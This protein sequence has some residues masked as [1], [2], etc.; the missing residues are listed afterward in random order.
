MSPVTLYNMYE[1]EA[2]GLNGYLGNMQQLINGHLNLTRSSSFFLRIQFLINCPLS[3]QILHNHAFSI[4]SECTKVKSS[5][6]LHVNNK[7]IENGT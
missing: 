1:Q 5:I 3:F 6:L 4:L 2:H 7:G